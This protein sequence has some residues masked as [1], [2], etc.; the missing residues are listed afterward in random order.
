ML[1]HHSKRQI[2]HLDP[3][4]ESLPTGMAV[5]STP[6]RQDGFFI[7]QEIS[8][9]KLCECGCGQSAPIAPYSC[10][11]KG[12]I[13]G[14][15]RRFIHGH[16]LKKSFRKSFPHN[17]Y[18]LIYQ[19]NHPRS[20]NSGYVREHILIAESIL[21]RPLPIYVVIHH[22]YEKA[23]TKCFIICENQGYHMLLH[24]RERAL[25]ASGHASWRKCP[26]CRKYDDPKNMAANGPVSYHRLCHANYEHE[27][28]SRQ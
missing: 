9:A 18:I 21:G 16:N 19:P 27:R 11:T 22:P 20:N 2:T 6:L 24:Q 8:M 14:E 7:S 25:R 17:G 28:R 12:W 4:E 13:K 26:Y 3:V 23:N 10:S 15:P 5:L 1:S